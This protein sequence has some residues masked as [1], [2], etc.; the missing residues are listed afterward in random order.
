[1][2]DSGFDTLNSFKTDITVTPVSPIKPLQ[3]YQPLGGTM[4]V[5]SPEETAINNE[6][7]II[8]YE[9]ASKA[10]DETPD[11][12]ELALQYVGKMIPVRQASEENASYIAQQLGLGKRVTFDEAYQ[13]IESQLGPLPKTPG[14]Q[15]SL[16]FLVDSLN[17]RTPY[18]G[19]AGIFD[20]LAQATGKYLERETAQKAADITHTLK[21]KEL[22]INQMKDANE[23]MLAKE[24][25]FFMKKMGIDDEYMQK[26]MSFTG[27]LALK[28]AQF[29]MD[30]I[31]DKQKAALDL[32]SNPNRLFQNMTYLD[33]NGKPKVVMTMKKWNDAKG[34][35]E[36]MMPRPDGQGG[37]IFDIEVPAGAYLSPLDGPQTD[38]ALA[39]SSPN[40]GQA[41]ELIGDFN[42]LG[43]AG[44]IVTNMLDIDQTALESGEPSRFGIE[45]GINYV[46]QEGRYT[47]ASLFDAFSPGA[48]KMF[49]DEGRTL[50]EKDQARY[51]LGAGEDE[52][53]KTINFEV[54]A[55]GVIDKGKEF[56]GQKTTKP[57]LVSI[58]D[59]F[60]PGTYVS[61]GYDESYAR[62]K[63]Q[64]NL[65]IYALARAL[66][67]TGRLNVDDIER[68]SSL[69]NLQGLKSPEYVRAQLKEILRFIRTAQVD[70]F[71]AGKY[72]EGKNIF[73]DQKYNTQVENYKRFIGELPPLPQ[74]APDSQGSVDVSP[75]EDPEGFQGDEILPEQ[76]FKT[77][78]I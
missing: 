32:Y 44:D 65:I 42:T 49:V 14:V 54:P 66:K 2:A 78:S 61:L 73:D 68:A 71:E 33:E 57:M 18:R 75:V 56:L 38:A 23:A 41:S 9:L 15:K 46:L 3:G 69:V 48:G 77:G 74:E 4:S 28:Q 36:Y 62:L 50:Y 47:L 34:E 31:K 37:T 1:M 30:V 22:A 67:P 16:N 11:W 72:G 6:K 55:T 13:G 51:P 21:M 10:V 35:Y 39:I 7:D 76:L 70:L 59:Y 19:A 20:V 24:A 43:R 53:F 52:K 12:N 5:T 64:E 40:Y 29:D 17:A 26:Y 60:R 63:V 45:G 58:E 27:D 25:E 8:N